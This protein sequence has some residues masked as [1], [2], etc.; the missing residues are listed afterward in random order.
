MS[1]KV[2][3]ITIQERNITLEET[4]SAD[5]IFITSSTKGI[6]PITAINGTQIGCGTVGPI[7]KELMSHINQF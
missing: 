4:M 7:S 6:M 3:G 1:L 2:T 5:E